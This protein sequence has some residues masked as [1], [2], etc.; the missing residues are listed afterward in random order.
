MQ[1]RRPV[2]RSFLAALALVAILGTLAIG[3]V[4]AGDGSL[5]SEWRQVRAAVARY[6]SFEQAARDGYTIENEPCVSSPDGTMGIHAINPA[7]MADTTI[8]PLRPE[9]LL[10][11]P[12]DNGQLEL[13][14]VEYW[15]ADADGDLATDDDRPTVLG[16]PVDGPMPGHNP[17]MPVHYDLHVWVAEEHPSD[18]FA[19]FNPAISC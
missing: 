15:M 1:G 7:L 6:H 3:A 13:V 10:Y 17:M 19:P 11:V 9:I 8:D 5:P 18:L 2:P 12:K 14:G 4:V 16:H